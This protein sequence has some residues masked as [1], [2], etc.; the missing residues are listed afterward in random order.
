MHIVNISYAYFT[1]TC[2]A[3]NHTRRLVKN[4]DRECAGGN[5]IGDKCLNLNYTCVI[6]QTTL[7]TEWKSMKEEEHVDN[8]LPSPTGNS[9]M[10]FIST[11]KNVTSMK[12]VKYV[13]TAN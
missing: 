9:S 13:E 4:E 1:D 5:H 3:L 10:Q 12:K 2:E 8:S 6:D 7:K 11:V